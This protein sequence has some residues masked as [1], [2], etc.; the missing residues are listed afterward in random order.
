[1][2]DLLQ[3]VS[4]VPSGHELKCK[5]GEKATSRCRACKKLLCRD[6]W[7]FRVKGYCKLYHAPEDE[8]WHAERFFRLEHE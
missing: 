7:H 6:A 8:I 3:R 1:M 4:P 5:C 2:F